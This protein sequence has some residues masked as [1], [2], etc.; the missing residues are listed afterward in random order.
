MKRFV[1]ENDAMTVEPFEQYTGKYEEW[2][3]RNMF[4][5]EAELHAV[6]WLLPKSGTGMEIGVG[7]GR[8]ATP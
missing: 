6:R 8:F 4:A 2:F 7:T 3:E 5:Y 1:A